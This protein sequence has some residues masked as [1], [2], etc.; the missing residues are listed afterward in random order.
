MAILWSS[1]SSGTSNRLNAVDVNDTTC[2]VVGD[3]GTLL[4]STNSGYSWSS[5]SHPAGSNTLIGV[6]SNGNTWVAVGASGTVIRSTNNGSSWSSVSSGT[7]L[8][9]TSVDADSDGQFIAV[10]RGGIVIRS[11]DNGSTWGTR[12]SGTTT[13]FLRIHHGDDGWIAVGR[14]GLSRQSGSGFVWTSST[15][16][17]GTSNTLFY[18]AYGTSFNNWI[19]SGLSAYFRR[20]TDRTSAIL[21]ISSN[22]H[23]I[24]NTIRGL[25]YYNGRFV[26]VGTLGQIITNNSGDVNT[27]WESVQPTSATLNDVVENEHGLIAI[28]DSGELLL[29]INVPVIDNVDIT[30]IQTNSA[31]ISSYISSLGSSDM[32]QHGHV[33]STSPN[34]TIDLDTKTELGNMNEV[35]HFVS[36][37]DNLQPYTTYYVKAYVVNNEGVFYSDQESFNTRGLLASVSSINVTDIT[38]NSAVAIGYISDLGYP[39]ANQHGHVW[40]TSPNPTIDLDTKTELG[41]PH[42]GEQF[43]SNLTGLQKGTIY[44][45]KPYISNS[46]G[47]M[48]G[49]EIVFKPS[50]LISFIFSDNEVISIKNNQFFYV[51]KTLSELAVE[52]FQEHGLEDLSPL[53]TPTT[54]AVYTMDH[55]QDTVDGKVYES[56]IYTKHNDVVIV[57]VK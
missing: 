17:T 30:D 35:G 15:S 24:L 26:G 13:D 29:G 55:V 19:I 12:N 7:S 23:G 51:S 52:D 46:E 40:D 31:V 11:T 39:E 22:A 1:I 20:A 18:A 16:S 27:T 44:Y 43:L 42:L 49:D 4:R 56:P 6:A 9:L 50:I 34:P 8:N 2:I 33:W 3:N 10:G 5:I 25:S 57:N 45:T 37:I 28:G 36:A 32:V 21:S 48:Y 38:T 41:V 53:T 14:S 54:K 47:T